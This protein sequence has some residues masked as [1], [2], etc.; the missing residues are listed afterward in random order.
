MEFV[1]PADCEPPPPHVHPHQ[2]ETYTVIEG[3]F[4]VLVDQ[5]WQTLGPGESASVPVGV[6]HTFRN[7]SGKLVRVQNW[8]EPALG[9]EDFIQQMSEDIERSGSR[10]ERDPRTM[11]YMSMAMMDFPETL[12]PTRKRDRW[13]MKIMATIGRLAGMGSRR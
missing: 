6:S 3:S 5:T 12:V 8:H 7:S 10:S 13:P 2:V 4:D 9:F 11:I 1:L